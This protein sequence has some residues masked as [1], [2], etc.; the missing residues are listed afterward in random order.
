MTQSGVVILLTRARGITMTDCA[1][2]LHASLFANSYNK[3]K[4]SLVATPSHGGD[5]FG[6]SSLEIASLAHWS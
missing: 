2:I 3:S 5:A 1:V 6:K 4:R